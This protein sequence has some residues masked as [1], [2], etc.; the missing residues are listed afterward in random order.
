MQICSCEVVKT[1]VQDT[2]R[3]HLGKFR[4]HRHTKWPLHRHWEPQIAWCAD[5]P[6]HETKEEISTKLSGND[7]VENLIAKQKSISRTLSHSQTLVLL[8]LR[9][10]G[11]QM[12]RPAL[13]R[14]RITWSAF[15]PPRSTN[16]VGLYNALQPEPIHQ[17]PALGKYSPDATVKLNLK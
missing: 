9:Y 3:D 5:L 10:S 16:Y 15:V 14:N 11:G 7:L 8:N 17:P 6:R 12:G 1:F 2:K 4:K 13:Q